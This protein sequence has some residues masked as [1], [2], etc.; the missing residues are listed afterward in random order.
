[1]YRQVWSERIVGRRQL[2]RCPSF[3]YPIGDGACCSIWSLRGEIVVLLLLSSLRT[4]FSQKSFMFFSNKSRGDLASFEN[5]CMSSFLSHLSRVIN[6]N[7]IFRRANVQLDGC[8]RM[9][10][11]A[12]RQTT[13]LDFATVWPKLQL[14]YSIG[15]AMARSPYTSI[16]YN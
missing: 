11:S 1:M 13:A 9:K 2:L 10:T 7:T 14:E 15:Q 4:S 6:M 16:E 12:V 5:R 8:G 3:L